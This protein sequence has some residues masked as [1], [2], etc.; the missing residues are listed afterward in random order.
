V[1]SAPV[2][3]LP[4]S[5]SARWGP[6]ATA[7]GFLLA[8]VATFLPWSTG[9]AAS[10]WTV[11]DTAWDDYAAQGG[12]IVALACAGLI[13]TALALGS[14]AVHAAPWRRWLQGAA[15]ALV[16]AVGAA[17]YMDLHQGTVILESDAITLGTGPGAYLVVAGGLVAAGAALLDR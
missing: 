2:A 6:A 17:S 14:R 5:P 7:G 16:A 15:G 13:V 9:V 4:A 11:S 1:D 3:E 10:G 12:M 8:I